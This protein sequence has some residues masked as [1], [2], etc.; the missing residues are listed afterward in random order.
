RMAFVRTPGSRN[1]RCR[2]DAEDDGRLLS[3]RADETA[4]GGI[5]KGSRKEETRVRWRGSA[6]TSRSRGLL[7]RRERAGRKGREARALSK[8]RSGRVAGYVRS[9]RAADVDGIRER[10]IERVG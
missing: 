8:S 3:R 4:Q 10:C 2:R 5:R 9:G 1:R 7:R 6:A